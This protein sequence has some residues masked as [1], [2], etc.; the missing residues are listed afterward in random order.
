LRINRK[1]NKSQRQTKT[2]SKTY[3][4][5]ASS[6]SKPEV[7]AGVESPGASFGAEVL[8]EINLSRCFLF[9]SRLGSSKKAGGGDEVDPL[10]SWE[11]S[12]SSPS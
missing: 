12:T 1:E 4:L 10:S 7:L 9:L 2:C 11:T 3:E 5:R 6:I 8:K